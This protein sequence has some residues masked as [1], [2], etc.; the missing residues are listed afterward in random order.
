MTR[1]LRFVLCLMLLCGGADAQ[2]VG[3]FVQGGGAALPSY[4]SP[5]LFTSATQT[6]LAGATDFFVIERTGVFELGAVPMPIAGT[7]TSISGWS[8]A[9]AGSGTSPVTLFVNGSTTGLTC[10]IAFEL[11]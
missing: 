6:L 9:T 2:I 7:F 11:E 3:A 1:L 4:V 8:N 5:L 10:S